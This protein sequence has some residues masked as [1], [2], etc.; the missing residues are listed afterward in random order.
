MAQQINFRLHD[1]EHDLLAEYAAE[2]GI[3]PREYAKLQ[4]L[5]PAADWRMRQVKVPAAMARDFMRKDYD[6]SSLERCPNGWYKVA[7][8]RQ[9]FWVEGYSDNKVEYE[10]DEQADS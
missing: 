2:W 1:S 6:G 10:V 7:G 4:M 5:A 9:W 8:E 3:K